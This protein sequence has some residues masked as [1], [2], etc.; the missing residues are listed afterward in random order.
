MLMLFKKVSESR[1]I[2]NI[3]LLTY[4]GNQ[5]PYE[6]SPNYF[7]QYFLPRDQKKL[8]MESSVGFCHH[9]SMDACKISTL[10]GQLALLVLSKTQSGLGET[11]INQEMFIVSY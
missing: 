11:L 7:N 2:I 10:F 9:N 3:Q 5:V 4:V 1:S 6:T 8:L